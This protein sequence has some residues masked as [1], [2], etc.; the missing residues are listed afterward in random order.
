MARKASRLQMHRILSA[1][2]HFRI[3]LPANGPGPCGR[4]AEGRSH[5]QSTVQDL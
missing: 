4:R 1:R 2:K 5:R 3:V